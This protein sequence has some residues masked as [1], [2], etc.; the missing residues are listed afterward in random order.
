[1]YTLMALTRWLGL[2]FRPSHELF[3]G[4][5]RSR[6]WKA[7]FI[8]SNINPCWTKESAPPA[9][10]GLYAACLMTRVST[11]GSSGRPVPPMG[12]PRFRLRLD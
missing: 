5:P 1:M 3:K 7:N 6:P 9:R 8:G 2:N 11:I 10:R 12:G 4:R